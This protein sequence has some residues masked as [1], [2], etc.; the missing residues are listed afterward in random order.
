MRREGESCPN[1]I[2]EEAKT[3]KRTL[4]RMAT[5]GLLVVLIMLVFGEFSF[6]ASPGGMKL[7]VISAG[8]LTIP[9]QFLT[10]FKGVGQTIEIPIPVYL[11]QHPRGLVMVDTGQRC[12]NK[13]DAVKTGWKCVDGDLVNKIKDLGFSPDDVKHVIMTHMHIDH[14]GYVDFFPKATFFIQK[15]ELT[16][17]TSPLSFEKPNYWPIDFTKFRD[18]NIVQLEGSWDVFGDGSVEMF[19]TIGHSRGHQSVIVRLPKTGAYILTGDAVYLPEILEGGMP[20][21]LWNG[22]EFLKS[23]Q[24]IKLEAERSQAQIFYSHDPDQFKTLKLSPKYYE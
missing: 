4:R 12:D 11:I 9:R 5:G 18:L 22:E 7:Y 16:A 10:G 3:M 15:D 6:A 13:P 19:R 23:V 14:A 21:I 24:R 1:L 2:E 8:A 20:G 17:L